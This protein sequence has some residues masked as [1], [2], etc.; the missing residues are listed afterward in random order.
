[1]TTFIR[2]AAVTIA[3]L[4]MQ[5]SFAVTIPA[6][7]TLVVRTLHNISSI[8]APGRTI[9]MQL[10]RDVVVNGKVALP[11]GTKI[12][13]RVETS[14]RTRTRSSSQEL[15]VNITNAQV[16]GR[17]VAIKTTGAVN[18]GNPFARTTRR[19]VQVSTYSYQV[20]SGTKLQFRLA[21]P[22]EF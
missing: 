20:P 11:A 22:V 5:A 1:M 8:D 9:S 10:D 21:Q 3:C 4:V 17:T 14:K 15:T 16:H 7:T 18:P 13:G 2:L 6:G 19:G 12:S